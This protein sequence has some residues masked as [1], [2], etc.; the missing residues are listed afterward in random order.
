MTE[1]LRGRSKNDPLPADPASVEAMT[2]EQV[3]F[4]R[5]A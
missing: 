5:R 2:E 1:Q 3:L 4:A